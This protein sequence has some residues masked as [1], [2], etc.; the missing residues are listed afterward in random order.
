MA[1]MPTVSLCLAHANVIN[2]HTYAIFVLTRVPRASP[3]AMASSRAPSC[4]TPIAP[5]IGWECLLRLETT[6]LSVSTGIA[7][8]VVWLIVNVICVWLLRMSTHIITT[9]KEMTRKDRDTF[10]STRNNPTRFEA[11]EGHQESLATECA[12]HFTRLAMAASRY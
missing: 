5:L 6:F 4:F 1:C 2:A 9:S 8:A 12:S 10:G 3:S 11:R 7:I